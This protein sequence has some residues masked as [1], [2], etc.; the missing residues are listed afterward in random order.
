M[1]LSY[2]LSGRVWVLGVLLC[3]KTLSLY[4]KNLWDIRGYGLS[5]TWVF[6][7]APIA[8]YLLFSLSIE[9][10]YIGLTGVMAGRS[11]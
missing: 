8:H 4:Q 10:Q 9:L 6:D 3:L 11:D 1:I 2:G 5:G 7:T